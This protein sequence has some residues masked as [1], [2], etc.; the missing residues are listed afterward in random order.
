MLLQPRRFHAPQPAQR[1]RGPRSSPRDNHAGRSRRRRRIRWAGAR[2]TPD[3]R[4][5]YAPCRPK[6]WRHRRFAGVHEDS[7]AG[8][9][10]PG[11]CE[12]Q[13]RRRHRLDVRGDRHGKT[14]DV[15]DHLSD[16]NRLPTE[17]WVVHDARRR[18]DPATE[19]D[20]DPQRCAAPAGGER[21]RVLRDRPHGGDAQLRCDHTDSAERETANDTGRFGDER[22]G[23]QDGWLGHCGSF[24]GVPSGDEASWANPRD[25]R[26]EPAGTRTRTDARSARQPRT[27]QFARQRQPR[28]K[29]HGH[30]CDPWQARLAGRHAAYGSTGAGIGKSALGSR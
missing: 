22:T 21:N 19:C 4:W 10:V 12:Q 11:G 25:S 30:V 18:V 17:T 9:G 24:G 5:G 3:R 1:L 13:F 15:G 6:R 2:S 26:T 7:A 20:A 23:R 29:G 8:S 16:R 27:T 28:A 14:H